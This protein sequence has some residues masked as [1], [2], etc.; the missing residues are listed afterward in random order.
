MSCSTVSFML[1]GVL[2]DVTGSTF[3]ATEA[4]VPSAAARSPRAISPAPIA[5]CKSN[6]ACAVAL[7]A[8]RTSGRVASPFV[9]RSSAADC[10]ACALARFASAACC[11]AAVLNTR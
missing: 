2:S 1:S 8:S 11:C 5:D 6:C 9:S 3:T 10:T 4:D 7:R